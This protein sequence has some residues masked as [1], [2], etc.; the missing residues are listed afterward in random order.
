MRVAG[1]LKALV[2]VDLPSIATGDD[3]ALAEQCAAGRFAR[4]GFADREVAR[5]GTRVVEILVFVDGSFLRRT[6]G[7]TRQHKGQ[8]ERTEDG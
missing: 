1:L 5:K 3:I 2:A 8:P 4:T 6:A 7:N